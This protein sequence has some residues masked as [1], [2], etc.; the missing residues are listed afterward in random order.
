MSGTSDSSQNTQEKSI[1]KTRMAFFGVSIPESTN[2]GVIF[3]MHT[4]KLLDFLFGTAMRYIIFPSAAIYGIT[5]A[6]LAWRMLRLERQVNGK[7]DWQKWENWKN[8]FLTIWETINASAT[9]IAVALG[10]I[11]A[12]IGVSAAVSAVIGLSISAI[13]TA[14]L[15]ATTLI[16]AFFTGFHCYKLYAAKKEYD[17]AGRPGVL[18]ATY[19]EQKELHQDQI[20]I[21]AIV[22]AIVGLLTTSV[23]L[24]MIVGFPVIGGALGMATC[25]ASVAYSA[26]NLYKLKKSNIPSSDKTT[27]APNN[28]T[29]TSPLSSPA[30]IQKKLSISSPRNDAQLPAPTT[31][32]TVKDNTTNSSTPSSND[33]SATPISS[34]DSDEEQ[35]N[36]NL[37]F[38]SRM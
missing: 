5:K 34:S 20:K 8:L 15:G 13:F 29:S 27:S 24:A 36:N 38:S 25:L 31:T 10:T 35:E 7:I 37:S 18:Q 6:I 11:A 17:K 23:V 33:R 14:A 26:Y 30:T 21:H 2:F 32:F 4:A 19:Q 9:T 16:H 1:Y 28:K 3:F 12:I 22:T